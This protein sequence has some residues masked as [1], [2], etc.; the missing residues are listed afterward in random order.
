MPLDRAT[1]EQTP[2]GVPV[3]AAGAVAAAAAL[4]AALAVLLAEQ[5]RRSVTQPAA[6]V[7]SLADV[8]RLIL[9]ADARLAAEVDQ[10][11]AAAWSR[12]AAAATADLQRAPHQVLVDARHAAQAKATIRGTYPHIRRWAHHAY[13]QTIDAAA[14]EALAGRATP[15]DAAQVAWGRLL[16]RGVTGFVDRAGRRWDLLTYVEMAVRTA[17]VQAAAQAHLDTL[18]AAGHRLVVVSDTGTVCDTCKPWRGQ[19]LAIVGPSGPHLVR[20]PDPTREGH[21]LQVRVKGTV[22]DAIAGGLWHPNCRHELHM[23][24]PGLGVPQHRE[25]PDGDALQ[26]RVRHVARVARSWALRAAG[27]LTATARREAARQ[28]RRARAALRALAGG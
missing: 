22:A 13:R 8:D 4:V 1:G 3:A 27:A 20:Q 14:A 25:D 24:R 7:L 15:L 9:A 23:W 2:G 17:V 26:R 18:A 6:H 12:G 21:W 16:E 19:T 10:V 5:I 28:A 11:V